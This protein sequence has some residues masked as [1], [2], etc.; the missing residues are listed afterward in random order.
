[1]K[2]SRGKKHYYLSMG[3]DFSVDREFR[4]T[5]TDYL[6]KVLPDFLETIQVIVATPAAEHLLTVR[7]DSDRKLLDKYRSTAFHHSV[8]KLLYSTPCVNKDIQTAVA[9]LT[10]KVR[11][12][13]G[14]YWQKLQQ[15]IQYIR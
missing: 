11:I 1:M 2:K 10:T 7:G 15:V 6:K 4:V 8:A 9:L 12:P 13:D 5:I 14:G 3:L